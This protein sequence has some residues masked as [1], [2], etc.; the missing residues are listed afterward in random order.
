MFVS[1][2][3]NAFHKRDMHGTAVYV[4]SGR[5]ATSEQARWLAQKENA[6]DLIGGIQS[7]TKIKS[8]AAIGVVWAVQRVID[9]V[10]VRAVA[11][12]ARH[13]RPDHG[14]GPDHPDPGCDP[15]ADARRPWC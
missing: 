6:A 14:D 2:H 13:Q 11:R 10:A 3:C 8:D 12:T 5:G 1:V 15:R 4:L 9:R 7:T